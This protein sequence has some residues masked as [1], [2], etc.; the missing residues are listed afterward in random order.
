MVT[1]YTKPNCV[2]C[3]M[4]KKYLDDRKVEYSTVDITQDSEA[5]DK[6][7]NQGFKAAPVVNAGSQWWSGFQPDLIDKHIVN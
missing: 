1:V 5:L 7:I 4:T 3:N 6:I 2:Q